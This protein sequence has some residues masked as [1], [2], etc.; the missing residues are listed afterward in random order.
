[1]TFDPQAATA[2]YID[3]LGAD[4]LASALVKTA[5]CRNPRP[6]ALEEQLFGDHPS[7]ERRVL[8]AMEWKPVHGAR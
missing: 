1:M 6:D 7:V 2:A 8:A 5:E 4:A 3:G